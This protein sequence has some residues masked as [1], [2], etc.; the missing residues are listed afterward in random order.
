MPAN[1]LILPFLGGFLLLRHLHRT[2][3]DMARLDTQRLLVWMALGGAALLFCSAVVT[4]ALGTWVPGAARL[5]HLLAPFPHSGKATGA[6]LLGWALPPLLN[7]LPLRA[8]VG[9]EP[10]PRWN[11][12][13]AWGRRA[14]VRY[15][16][17]IERV[18]IRAQDRRMTVMA[19][20]GSGKVYVGFV[21]RNAN[22]EVERRYVRLF[23]VVS[24]YR[25]KEDHNVVFT[26]FYDTVREQ[27]KDPA[28]PYHERLEPDFDVVFPISEIKTLHLYDLRVYEEFQRQRFG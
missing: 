26:T 15:G 20:L 19:T 5:W 23:P 3:F 13:V 12:P 24:G 21:E 25:E 4:V 17:E 28:S 27:A 7:R 8:A 9:K 18:L 1:L 11:D 2:R 10:K 6:L 14:I 22:L 16:N